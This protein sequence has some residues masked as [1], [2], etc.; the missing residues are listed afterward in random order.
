LPS[1][2]K[3]ERFGKSTL[4]K[5]IKKYGSLENWLNSNKEYKLNYERNKKLVLADYIP[6]NIFKNIV[7]NFENQNPKYNN[8]EFRNYIYDNNFDNLLENL[9]SNFKAELSLEDFL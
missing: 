3:K 2:F 5:E 9:P 6:E 8:K 1:I 7:E 4:R